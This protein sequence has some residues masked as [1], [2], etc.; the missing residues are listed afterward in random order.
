MFKHARMSV[1]LR[2]WIACLVLTIAPNSFSQ[3]NSSHLLVIEGGVLQNCVVTIRYFRD[4]KLA[5]TVASRVTLADGRFEEP[6][7]SDHEGIEVCIQSASH[8]I[9][10]A[11]RSQEEVLDSEKLEEPGIVKLT[12]GRIGRVPFKPIAIEL[13]EKESDLVN[14]LAI[15]MAEQKSSKALV[16][17]SNE[18]NIDSPLLDVFLRELK[19]ILGIPAKDA[20]PTDGWI[21]WSDQKGN[22]IL[23]GVLQC[24]RGPCGMRLMLKNNK[25][26]DLTPNCPALPDNYFHQPVE[27][28]LYIE[29][30]KQL[31]QSLFEGDA[32]KAHQLYSPRFRE[33]VTKDQLTKVC[34]MVRE[35][36]GKKVK[37]AKLKR[38]DVSPYD[39]AQRSTNLTL[40]LLLETDS[41]ARCISRTVFNIPGGRHTVGKA[42]LGAINIQQVF[43][44]S[45]PQFS[46]AT[47]KL[48]TEIGRGL[49]AKTLIAALP[50]EL[51]TIVNES[52]LQATLQRL[53]LP[54]KDEVPQID[55]DLWAMENH[56]ERVQATGPL[57]YGSIDYLAEA[58]F[59]GKESLTGF[60]L[61]GPSVA[62]STLGCFDFD[63]RYAELAQRF[64]THLLRE[65]AENAH[66]LLASEF[67]EQLT[68]E[69]LKAQLESPKDSQSPLKSIALDEVRL[70]SNVFRPVPVM[71][72]VFLTATFEDD[73]QLSL[74]CDVGKAA[75]EDA[76][77][78]VVFD[79][80]SDFE[81]HYPVEKI[82]VAGSNDDGADA[83]IQ[84]LRDADIE[85]LSNLI[86][87]KHRRGIDRAT[88][89]AYLKQLQEIGSQLD[90]PTSIARTAE[91]QSGSKRYRCNS[92]LTNNDGVSIPVEVWFHQGFLERFALSEPRMNDFVRLVDDMSGIQS[93]I[94]SFIS[95]WFGDLERVKEFQ[96][97]STAPDAQMESLKSMRELFEK[98]HGK[99]TDATVNATRPY[100]GS[101]SLEFE[102]TLKG[103]SKEKNVVVRVEVGAFGG[104]ISGVNF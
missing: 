80:S 57:K 4:R 39:F 13:S 98:E 12:V 35:R 88:L 16:A 19:A 59:Q 70:A 104:L 8:P 63:P 77:K 65:E 78:P 21:A 82:P 30:A 37:S 76:E 93:R 49:D 38:Y 17:D 87:P 2:T 101:G 40:D 6:I 68:L 33:Q 86:A 97:S 28:E 62:E 96:L 50:L 75:G 73:G 46:K 5:K 27:V 53:A 85:S 92:T 81:L 23:V 94:K 18:A 64:W 7:E 79:F 20:N 22:R 100:G 1:R 48:L 83:A 71:A 47:E 60:S 69:D 3:D 91:Y 84:A 36:F 34:E 25:L 31:T 55:F 52:K 95:S 29:Q 51:Q 14:A 11:I 74:A 41:D 99:L 32:D 45:Y 61:Y 42:H 24:E 56:E 43:Q 9:E 54:L 66:A 67:K 10:A 72:T 26:V 103:E 89:A 90:A 15:A 44:S 102:V 58:H